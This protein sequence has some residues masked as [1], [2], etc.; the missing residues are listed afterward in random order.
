MSKL[1]L[2]FIQSSRAVHNFRSD[3]TRVGAG[4]SSTSLVRTFAFAPWK[5][6]LH[7]E[8]STAHRKRFFDVALTLLCAPLWVPACALVAIAI[9]VSE[10]RPVFYRSERRTHLLRTRRVVKFR[11]MASDAEQILNRETVP[12]ADT[13]FLNI[14]IEHPVYTR[15]GRVIERFA[16]TELPQLVDVL[17][18]NMSLVGNR[19]LPEN[20]VRALCARYPYA[21]DRFITRSGLTGPVQLVGRDDISDEDRLGIEIDYCMVSIFG[22]RMRLD[23]LILIYTVLI[24]LR[25]R[26]PLGV[27]EVRSLMHSCMAGESAAPVDGL[28]ACRRE[29]LRFAMPQDANTISLHEEPYRVADFSY[30]GLRIVGRQSLYPGERHFVRAGGGGAAIGELLATV[31]WCRK[32]SVSQMEIGLSWEPGYGAAANLIRTVCDPPSA[33]ELATQFAV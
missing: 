24:A 11:T 32:I 23:L 9:W 16:L 17:A 10:G 2:R 15:I 33:R 20:V 1:P 21:E 18:G 5:R 14:P 4:S 28:R 13:C 27:A 3:S 19:P 22:Y 26:R 29:S 30:R 31:Q 25:V 7:H 6:I 12:I 8:P